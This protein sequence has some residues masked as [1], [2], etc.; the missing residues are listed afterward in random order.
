MR[1]INNLFLKKQKPH[2]IDGVVGVA[3]A[4]IEPA[5]QGFSVLCSLLIINKLQ[6]KVTKN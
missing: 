1:K 3:P 5:T 6:G 4:G 2:R